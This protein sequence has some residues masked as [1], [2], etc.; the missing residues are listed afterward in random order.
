MKLGAVAENPVESIVKALGLSPE[1][2][3]ETH[4]AMLLARAVMEGSRLGIYETLAAGPLTAAEV[5][6]RCG[7]HPQ[8][9][10]KLL[11]ALAGSGYLDF[12]AGRY[13]LTARARKWL[14]PDSP[15]SLHDKMLLQFVEWD[16]IAHTGEYLRTG[17]PID[18][19]RSISQQEW[20]L[21]QR[22]MRSA[23]STWAPEVARRTP[24]PKGAKDMLDIGGS[25]GFL[26]VVICRKHPGLRSVILDLAEAVEHAGPILGREGLGDRVTH[27]IGDAL[28][29]DLGT[30]AWDVVFIANL[31]HHFDDA[32][33]RELAKRVARSLRPG[34]V[35][36]VQELIRPHSPN[37]AGQ[38]GALLDLYFALSS[39]SGTWSFEEIA[40]W[41][42]EAGLKPLKP[43]KF[44]TVPG[45][46]QQSAVKRK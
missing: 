33:N 15:Q 35:F 38:I 2:L 30:E 14:L 23:S 17:K 26:S 8:A 11:D 19:H 21:Y 29:D 18:L 7:G 10:R 44:L 36:V 40:S 27:R 13:S 39:Q 9:I 6:G 46:G 34:G 42:R 32:A 20:G 4:I 5:A 45:N 16:F 12:A 28:V 1:P 3:L 41:Q 25:H 43:V 24:V 22:G 37:E 31:V